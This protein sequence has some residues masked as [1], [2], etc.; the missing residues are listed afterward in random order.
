M[1]H[2]KVFSVEDEEWDDVVKSFINYDIYYFRGYVR[3]FQIHGDGVPQLLY[4][5]TSKLRAIYVYMKRELDEGWWDII[6]PYG[7]G[8]LLFEGET[9]EESLRMF[10]NEFIAQMKANKIVANFVRFHPV[11]GNANKNRSICEVMDLGQTIAIDLDSEETVWNNFTSKN[12]NMVRKAEKNG[13]EIKHG[14]GMDL[15]DQFIRIYNHTMDC[16]NAEDYY[17]FKRPFYESI[18]R[19]L[20]ENYEMFYAVYNTEIIAMSIM[21]FANG[22]MHYH[23][24]GSLCEYRTLAPTNLLLYQA[25]LWGVSQGF[26]SFHLGGG[27]GS[28]RDNLYKF[29][30]GFNRRSDL[31]FSIGK[32]VFCV[33]KYNE[34]VGKRKKQNVDFDESSS[35]FP[36][37][38]SK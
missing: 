29:K 1:N 23:L 17:Y 11:L 8:G 12:R 7:Y 36:L 15:F 5:H 38:R 6:T 9:D 14:K 18:E 32:Q 24:S 22:N 28:S 19:D 21:L 37:Y 25:A 3:A 33:E 27:V 31:L 35:F 2:I 4:Y 30:E 16:D 26:K 13:I 20:A 10:N 34:L